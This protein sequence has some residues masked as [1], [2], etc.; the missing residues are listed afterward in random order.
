[1]KNYFL[2]SFEMALIKDVKMYAS[3]F[4][5]SFYFAY[6]GKILDNQDLR[7]YQEWSIVTF[8]TKSASYFSKK[9]TQFDEIS[10]TMPKTF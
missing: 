3:N 5:R 9:H 7:L 8:T 10:L 1:M 6:L 2:V 4:W